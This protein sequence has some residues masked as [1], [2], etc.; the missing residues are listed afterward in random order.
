MENLT[1]KV[2]ENKVSVVTGGNRGLGFE[3]CKQ[4]AQL[5][6]RVILTSRNSESGIQAKTALKQVGL[7]VDYCCVDVCKEADVVHLKEYIQKYYGRLDIL[8]NNAGI[9]PDNSAPGVFT[10]KSILET[11]LQLILD[12]FQTNALAVVRVCRELVPLMRKNKSGRIV[13]VSS[14]S[15]QLKSMDSGIPAYRISKVAL[16]A[17]TRILSDELKGDSIFC[18]SVSPGW[19]KTEM[20]GKEAN[21]TVEDG[22]RQIVNICLLQDGSSGEFFRNGQAIEW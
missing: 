8:I 19:V 15:A 13:N 22:A 1:Q 16:N 7:V 18:N 12:A 20:G 6:S 2:L 4:L 5:G 10:D 11:D 3:V 17:V 21:V 14:L 9:L